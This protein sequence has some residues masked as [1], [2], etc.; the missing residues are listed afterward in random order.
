[1]MC[2]CIYYSRCN[3]SQEGGR[4]ICWITQGASLLYSDQGCTCGNA[5]WCYGW[6]KAGG[7][8]RVGLTGQ[9]VSTWIKSME[10][11]VRTVNFS[12]S[13]LKA[14]GW[15][16]VS[17]IVANPPVFLDGLHDV[18]VA[19]LGL[20]ES[21]SVDGAIIGP[22]EWFSWRDEEEVVDYNEKGYVAAFRSVPGVWTVKQ[23][24]FKED[25]GHL[26]WEDGNR[27]LRGGLERWGWLE[28]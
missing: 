21:V 16:M 24:R 19:V 8:F 25:Y 26:W 12:S 11:K 9:G 18:V 28:S 2:L 20:P 13:F 15:E 4:E 17:A 27:R 5:A 3:P 6:C 1:M 14:R 23:L 10:V 22:S 7:L